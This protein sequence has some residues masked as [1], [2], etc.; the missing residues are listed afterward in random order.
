MKNEG[1][2]NAPYLNTVTATTIL[3]MRPR[4][5][6]TA[7]RFANF[8]PAWPRH[9]DGQ[10]TEVPMRSQP[11][12]SPK[13]IGPASTGSSSDRHVTIHVDVAACIRW[14]LFGLAILLT[15]YYARPQTDARPNVSQEKSTGA[16]EAAR[17][18]DQIDRPAVSTSLPRSARL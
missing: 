12:N 18:I 9:G 10:H 11:P 13:K 8:H 15:A 14:L 2:A 4:G 17:S 5:L 6:P 7:R 3:V 1:D 16:V